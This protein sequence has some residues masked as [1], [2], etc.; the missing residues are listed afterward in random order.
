MAHLGQAHTNISLSEHSLCLICHW[1]GCVPSALP[2]CRADDRWWKHG[3]GQSRGHKR[4][5]GKRDAW[6]ISALEHIPVHL[7]YFLLSPLAWMKCPRNIG[8]WNTRITVQNDLWLARSSCGHA[9]FCATH[10]SNCSFMLILPITECPRLLIHLQKLL[11][12]GM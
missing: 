8:H 12:L 5:V 9:T 3:S 6:A 11:L 1:V 2:P 10:T 7:F 4:T